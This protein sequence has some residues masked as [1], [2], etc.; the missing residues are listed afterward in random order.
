MTVSFF[1]LGG[2]IC[3]IFSADLQMQLDYSKNLYG[4]SAS[5][6]K[7]ATGTNVSLS[8]GDMNNKAYPGIK[9]KT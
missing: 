1:C 3:G 5:Q 9:V 6:T 4:L 2:C 7:Q 8:S